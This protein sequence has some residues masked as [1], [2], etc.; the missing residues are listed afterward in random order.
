MNAVGKERYSCRE[1]MTD[2]TEFLGG[3]RDVEATNIDFCDN[4][5]IPAFVRMS[6]QDLLLVEDHQC[7]S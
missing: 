5:D 7:A 4:D 1:S 2:A 6:P 3:H